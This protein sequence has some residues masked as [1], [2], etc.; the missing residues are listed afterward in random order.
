MRPALALVVAVVAAIGGSVRASGASCDADGNIRFVCGQAGPEDLVVVPG[1]RWIISSG[2]AAPGGLH[3]INVRDQ[4]TMVLFPKTGVGDRLDKTLYGSCPGPLGAAEGDRFSAHGI[5]LRS[6]ASQQHKVFVVHHGSR[7]SVEM[8]IVDARLSTP[9]LTWVGC[10]VA[11][12]TVQLNSV[13]GLPDGGVIVTNFSG[14]GA[15]AVPMTRVMAGENSGDLWEWHPGG[16]WTKVPGTDVSGANGVEISSDGKWLYIGAWG[17]QAVVRVSRGQT[18]LK[19]D[20]V[21]VGF[22][23]D[24]L[25]FGADGLLLA[26]GQGAVA[27]AMQVE[28]GTSHVE[29]LDPKNLS[30]K[31]LLDYSNTKAFGMGTTAVRIGS[32]LWVGSAVGDRIA[33]FPS[34]SFRKP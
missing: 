2:V 10:V 32:N 5:Y 33:I 31:K 7:E 13:A 9:T 23:V 28:G 29:E 26:T 25:R 22:R 19:R 30:H 15:S 1:G 20:S 3:L 6:I 34:E 24:N 8:F 4:T 18:P 21:P 16:T 14:R 12:D 17:N 27:N 11:P